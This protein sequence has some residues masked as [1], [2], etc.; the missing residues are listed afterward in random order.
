[1]KRREFIAASAFC[2]ALPA[3]PA[4]ALATE[5]N[6]ARVGG[7]PADWHNVEIWF[8]GEWSGDWVDVNASE[9][10]GVRF[11]KDAKGQH[12]LDGNYVRYEKKTGAF[13]LRYKESG[14]PAAQ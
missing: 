9:G 1:M 3:I 11:A 7:P 10:W 8:D 2:A 14:H 12:I 5:L 13:R 4:F 6:H